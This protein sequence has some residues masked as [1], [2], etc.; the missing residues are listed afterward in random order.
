MARYGLRPQDGPGGN[1]ILRLVDHVPVRRGLRIAADLIDSHDA[2]SIDE[3]VE[4]ARRLAEG[5]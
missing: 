2:R 4:I 1:V 3:G 5:L